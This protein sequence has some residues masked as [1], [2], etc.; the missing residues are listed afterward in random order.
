MDKFIE[1]LKEMD[2]KQV[3]EVR[4]SLETE[5]REA[6]SQESLEEIK[7]KVEEVQTRIAELKDL[8]TRKA[9]ALEIEAGAQAKKIEEREG[10]KEMP[11]MTMEE[12]RDKKQYI[13]AYA[14]YVK[15]GKDE[16]IRALLTE[17]VENG[18]IAVPTFV[19]DIVKTAWD[20]NEIMK[21]VTKT[22]LA[23]N[24]KVQ[25][26]I[27]GDDAIVHTEGSGA[28]AE[29]TLTEGIVTLVPEYIKKWISISDEVMSMR[30]EAFLRYIYAELTQKIVKKLADILVGKIAALPQV[31]TATSPAAAKISLAP[32]VGTV[33]S[34]IG[35]LSDE[36]SNPVVVM[37]KL[38]WSEFKSAQYANGFNVD[39]FEGLNVHFNNSLPAY[40]AAGVGDVYLI[41]GDFGQGA[42]ANYPNGDS[43]EFKFDD[44]TRKKEDLVE[45]LGKEYAAVGVVANK[46]F[47]LVAKPAIV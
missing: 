3:E 33:A 23:G 18:T 39:P 26:E 37:N 46:A 2:L 44:L 43:I 21:L 42:L 28:V 15:T 35:N 45:V 14:E 5:I 4:A 32:A 24:L 38:T 11:K 8:E 1:S 25:F 19:Y 36:A 6:T 27:S 12:F 47:T 34:A 30:G 17:N 31:A 41:V 9:A 22:E 29:E 20:K 7:K 16:E 10:D 40:S 13:D